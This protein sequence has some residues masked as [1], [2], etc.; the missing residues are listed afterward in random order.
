M[1]SPFL[2]IW[3]WAHWGTPGFDK[4]GDRGLK[5]HEWAGDCKHSSGGTHCCRII[6]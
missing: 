4:V 1:K 5:K 2:E 6:K 3:F